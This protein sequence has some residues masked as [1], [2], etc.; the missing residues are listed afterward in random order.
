M[1]LNKRKAKKAKTKKDLM[2]VDI[3]SLDSVTINQYKRVARELVR[4]TV[5]RWEK[6]DYKSPAYYALMQRTGGKGKILFSGKQTLNQQKK[7][8]AKAVRFLSDPSVSRKGWNQIKQQN[9]ESLY[10]ASGIALEVK[11]YDI[12]FKTYEKLKELNSAASGDEYRYE[13]MARMEAA[14]ND[15]NGL[16]TEDG[17]ILNREDDEKAY[18]DL[19]AIQMDKE[20]KNMIHEKEAEHRRNL[21]TRSQRIK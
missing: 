3:S 4:Q 12:F 17:T 6:E 14:L 18:I 7:E 1:A 13:I 10:D 8:L 11:D 20:L 2:N 19:L 5:K 16:E 9:I 21:T 15:E